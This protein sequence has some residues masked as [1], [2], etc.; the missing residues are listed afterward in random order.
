MVVPENVITC[1]SSVQVLEKSIDK[2]K[3]KKRKAVTH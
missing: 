2:K 3:G 1:G